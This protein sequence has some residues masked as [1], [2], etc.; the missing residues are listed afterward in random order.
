MFLR[1]LKDLVLKLEIINCLAE[2]WLILRLRTVVLEYIK[3]F[4]QGGLIDSI[5]VFSLE[6]KP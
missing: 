4:N 2:Y 3:K 5:Q 1:I 6:M